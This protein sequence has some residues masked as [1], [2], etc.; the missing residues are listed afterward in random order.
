[1][2]TYF[3]AGRRLRPALTLLCVFATLTLTAQLTNFFQSATDKSAVAAVSQEISDFGLLEVDAEVYASFYAEAPSGDWSVTLPPVPGISPEMT[4][5]LTPRELTAA[6][7]GLLTASQ[8]R[9]VAQPNLGRHFGGRVAGQPNSSVALSLLDGELTAS[10]NLADGRRLSLGQLRGDSRKDNRATYVL[11]PNHQLSLGQEFNC[12]T[13]DSQVPYLPEELEPTTGQKSSG[14]C[15]EVYFE[16]DHD[17]YLHKGASTTLAAQHIMANFNEVA[18]LFETIGVNMRVSE[19]FVWDRPSPYNGTNTGA[20]L[21]QF[22]QHRTSF[23]GDLAQLVAFHNRGGVAVL[24]GLCHPATAARMSFSGLSTTFNSVPTYSWSTMVIAHEFGHSLG[25]NH[26]HACVW[27]GNGTAI[28]GCAAPQ[29]NCAR[30]GV[31]SGGGTIMSYC[32]LTASGINFNR[33][34]GAQPGALIASRVAAAQGCLQGN[35]NHDDGHNDDD[36]NG[37][38]GNH[39]GDDSGDDD[40]DDPQDP[41]AGD[42]FNCDERPVYLT[43]RLDDFGTETTWLI[44]SEAGDTLATGGPYPKKQRGRLMQDSVCLTEGCF[45]LEVADEHADGMCCGFGDGY[46]RIESKDNILIGEG[47]DFDSLAIIDFCLPFG[48]EEEEEDDPR[49]GCEAIDFGQYQVLSYGGNQDVGIYQIIENGAGIVLSNNAWKAIRMDYDMTPNTWLSFWFKSTRTGEVHGI[50]MDN[51]VVL[52]ADMTLRLFGTQSWGDGRFADYPGDGQ[53]RY[54]QIPIG[55]IYAV[56]AEYLFFTADHDVGSRNGNSF[57][58]DI[59]VTE[60]AP[61]PPTASAPGVGNLAPVP[62]ILLS[63]NPASD[64]LRVDLSAPAAGTEYEIYDMTGRRMAVG[65]VPSESFTVDVAG[66]VT[67]TYLLRIT[68]SGEERRSRFVVHR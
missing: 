28:D 27:N 45:V 18:I 37:G 49:E 61:C 67:G 2:F 62:E 14:G 8:D 59:V 63:P 22:Q 60:G 10:I 64:R 4:L 20:V 33:G 9:P 30:P 35:C 7:F 6:G 12:G 40:D 68:G 13:V 34:F 46:F 5:E 23:N 29:G 50:G 44:R 38:G 54:Y 19:M 57:F 21:R 32:H 66:L 41:P 43:F 11:F 42:F 36:D 15:V 26:T 51:N 25:S 52:S 47:S 58:R 24:D 1:M 3:L 16:I 48:D 31:P 65:S 39:G 17:I 55:S 56:E 53:W